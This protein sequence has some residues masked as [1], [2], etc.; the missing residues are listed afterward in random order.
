[1]HAHLRGASDQTGAKL[2][3][4]PHG[5]RGCTG[6]PLDALAEVHHEQGVLPGDDIKNVGLY[7]LRDLQFNGY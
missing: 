2:A 1:M 7:L 5:K 6:A 3:Q 4:A